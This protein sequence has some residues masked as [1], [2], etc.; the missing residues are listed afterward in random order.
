MKKPSFKTQRSHPLM[1]QPNCAKRVP[2]W[3]SPA[4]SLALAL[5]LLMNL[6]ALR[7]SFNQLVFGQTTVTT[8]AKAGWGFANSM[9]ANR[10]DHTATRLEDG[11]VLVAGGGGF[12]CFEG[13]CYATVN[14]SSELYDPI[15]GIWS[16]TGELRQ[17]RSGHTATLLKDGRVLI[18]GG[19]DFGFDIGKFSNLNSA[20]LYDPATGKWRPTAGFNRIEG[21]NSAT[22]LASGKVLAVGRSYPQG[23][24]AEMYDPVTE[25]WSITAAPSVRG[26]AVLLP[27]GKVLN[28]SNNTPDIY[29]PATETWSSAAH[30][31]AIQWV[32]TATLLSN[33][34]VL[35]TGTDES[36]PGAE[37]YDPSTGAWSVTGPPIAGLGR[38]TP[39]PEGRALMTGGY[40]SQNLPSG[41]EI[42]D[43]ETGQ[44][45]LTDRL[46]APRFAH[47]ATLLLDGRVL[48]AGGSQDEEGF[49][50]LSSAEL[51]GLIQIIKITSASVSGRKLFLSGENF[52][53]GAVILRNG[54][55]EK[56][57]ND[58]QNPSTMLI[59]K[60]AGKK[61]KAGDKLQVRN[62]DGTLSEEF[63]F[64]GSQAATPE[65]RFSLQDRRLHP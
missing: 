9:H 53:A 17:R 51:Y 62:P 28:V 60:K 54:E 24:S 10:Y 44:W 46:K 14:S 1:S 65:R 49:Y 34:K 12:P 2:S 52:L 59:G 19:A 42:Y 7:V 41:E 47:T 11:K 13:Y 25:T 23:Y 36:G 40:T 8:A 3:L 18:A 55:D 21:Y 56:T 38:V 30:L 4:A 64:S 22:L 6:P 27:D 29:D 45:S 61:I 39:L 5:V 15:K 33:G 35:A 48:V 57:R 63:I 16:V 20:E 50:I 31:N 58:D 26:M 37:L 43:P 32:G